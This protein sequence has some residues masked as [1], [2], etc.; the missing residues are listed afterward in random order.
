[1]IKEIFVE[2]AAEVMESVSPVPAGRY[3]QPEEVAN[4]ALF[5]ASDEA[6]FMHGSVI[7]M[8]GGWLVK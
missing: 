4:L 1:M 2:G 3:G 8:D 6:S 7:P 5:L